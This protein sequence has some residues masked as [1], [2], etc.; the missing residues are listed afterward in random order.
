[1]VGGR[2]FV[3]AGFVALMP[4]RRTLDLD[5]RTVRHALE[6]PRPAAWARWSRSE[7]Q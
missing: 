4:A 7:G 5:R 2:F 1:V 6:A 3:A